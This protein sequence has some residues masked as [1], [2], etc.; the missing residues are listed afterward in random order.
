MGSKLYV[1]SRLGWEYDD[2]YYHQP[3]SGGGDPVVAYRSKKKAEEAAVNSNIAELKQRFTQ[4]DL[5]GYAG[6]EG[7][8]G[9][10]G[11]RSSVE[12]LF[13]LF[14]EYDVIVTDKDSVEYTLP[15]SGPPDEF[16]QKLNALI[17]MFWFSVSEIE[18]GDDT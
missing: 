6:E 8:T 15:D 12:P 18:M 13:Q 11:Y 2:N 5:G 3:E 1:V 7:W 17:N 14:D 9:L 4:G 16:F 10:I